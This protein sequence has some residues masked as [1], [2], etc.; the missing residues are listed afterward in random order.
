MIALDEV[1]PFDPARSALEMAREML[2]VHRNDRGKKAHNAAGSRIKAFY[3][4]RAWRSARYNFLKTQTNWR[5]RCCGTTAAQARLVVD[6]VLSVREHWDRRLDPTNF[7]VLCD[8]CNLAKGSGDST[9]FGTARA[10]P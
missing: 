10:S 5:C 7:Q 2:R 1:Q 3:T 9:R 8:D 4:T 6:H